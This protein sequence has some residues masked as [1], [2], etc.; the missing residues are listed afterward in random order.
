[1]HGSLQYDH[2]EDSVGDCIVGPG[3]WACEE[4]LWSDSAF[5][6]ASLV[7]QRWGAEYVA[8]KWE[9]FRMVGRKL[10]KHRKGFNAASFN[11]TVGNRLRNASVVAHEAAEAAMDVKFER[12]SV[13]SCG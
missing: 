9:D 11:P 2:N 4:A 10:K 1:M 5:V 7:A 3:H 6:F 8:I 13:S 12:S